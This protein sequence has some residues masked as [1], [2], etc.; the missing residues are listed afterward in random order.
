MI[1][2]EKRAEGRSLENV[3]N[4]LDEMMHKLIGLIWQLWKHKQKVLKPKTDLVW[5]TSQIDEMHA[6]N[7]LKFQLEKISAIMRLETKV[8]RCRNRVKIQVLNW[9]A[10]KQL[11][12]TMWFASCERQLSIDFNDR[13]DCGSSA[14]DMVSLRRWYGF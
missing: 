10:Q 14:A 1:S 11:T 9:L 7:S 8:Q 4:T 2:E 13:D 12:L 3:T 6:G 5:R